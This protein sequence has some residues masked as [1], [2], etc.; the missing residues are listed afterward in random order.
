MGNHQVYM[1]VSY[2]K[3]LSFWSN[4]HGVSKTRHRSLSIRF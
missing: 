1:Q 3:T 4:A 2:Y